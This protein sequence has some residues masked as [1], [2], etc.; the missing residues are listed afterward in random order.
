[1][2]FVFVYAH[3]CARLHH[4]M[5]VEVGGLRLGVGSGNQPQVVIQACMATATLPYRP[6]LFFP[7]CHFKADIFILIKACICSPATSM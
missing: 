3:S 2:Y 6:V 7:E 5:S 1:M 4:S